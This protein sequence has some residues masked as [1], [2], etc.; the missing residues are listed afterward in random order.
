[1]ESVRLCALGSLCLTTDR[2]SY[3]ITAAAPALLLGYLICHAANG[4]PI[5]RSRLAGTLWPDES[6]TRARRNLTDTLYRLRRAIEVQIADRILHVDDETI[7]LG[8]VTIDVTE[9]RRLAASAQAA[10]WQAALD[11][12]AGDLLSDLDAD[13]LLAPREHLH[14]TYLATLERVCDARFTSGA[15]PEAL[16]IALRWVEA[17]PLSENAHAT[18]MRLY[19]RLGRHADALRQYDRLVQLLDR[20]LKI[21]PLPETRSLAASLRSEI[22]LTHRVPV[23]AASL[24]FVGRVAERAMLLEAVEAMIAGR[25]GMIAVEGEAGIGKSRLLDE[26]AASAKW[27]GVTV[28]TGR[29]TEAPSASPL[30]PLTEVL[31]SAFDGARRAQLEMLLPDETLAALAPLI[32]RWRD[33]AP[34]PDLPPLPARQ[35]FHRAWCEV[36]QTLA[37]IAPHVMVIDDAHWATQSVWEAL[38]EVAPLLA[39][40]RVLIVVAYRRA[41]LES[42]SGWKTVQHWERDG[43]LK[44]LTLSPLDQAEVA[45]LLP[46]DQNDTAAE[47]L[48]LTGGNPFYVMQALLSEQAGTAAHNVDQ[49]VLARALALS[50]VEREA[51]SAAAVLGMTVSF[52]LWSTLSDLDPARLIA[53]ADR[54]TSQAFLQ[55]IAAGYAF[56]HDLIQAIIY[57]QIDPERQQDLHRRAARAVREF[58]PDNAHALAFHLDR[59]GLA[60][61]AAAA[62]RRVGEQDRVRFAF[63]EARAAFERALD[64]L[65]DE[66]APIRIETLLALAQVCDVLGARECQHA[67]IESARRAARQLGDSPL[68]IRVLLLAGRLAAQTGQLPAA[69]DTYTEVL[70]LAQQTGDTTQ[71]IEAAFLLGDLANR[72]GDHEAASRRYQQVLAQAESLGDRGRMARALRGLGMI[73]RRNGQPAEAIRW[74]ERAL[75][76]QQALG[77][78]I[79][80]SITRVNLLS[81]CY[82]LGAWDR[83]LGLAEETQAL[84]EALHRKESIALVRHLQGLACFA[85]GDFEAA[86]RCLADAIRL[87]NEIGDRVTAGLA[88][89]AI[90]LVAEAED[91]VAGAQREYEAALAAAV[92]LN[93]TTEAAY[94]QHDLGA[95]LLRLNHHTAAIPLL[96]AARAKWRELGNDLLR[97]KSEAYLGLALLANG[98]R[99]TA[100]EL[101][102][103]NWQALQRGGLSGEQPQSWLW[104]LQRLLAQLNQSEQ[105]TAVLRAAYAELQ[106]QGEAIADDRLRQQFFNRVPLNRSIVAA[107]DQLNRR[108]RR[109]TIALVRADVPLGRKLTDR[110]YVTIEWTI[111]APE[112]DALTDPVDRRRHI[113]SRL[114]AEARSAGAAPTDHD[115]SRALDVSR[116]TIMRDIEALLHSGVKLPTRRRKP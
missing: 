102:E 1:M 21:E 15:L 51:L 17:D 34:L 115:L 75:T 11:L 71:Q 79:G 103:E 68:M 27:R 32:D 24:P 61:E 37:A 76:L 107:Y 28:V 22:E 13:W 23:R 97:L 48:A 56:A 90:G 9:F 45:Q 33:R 63:A 64:L 72:K 6:E 91:D 109:F 78:R 16:A 111:A 26:V 69:E 42:T 57:E 58:D 106:R 50:P 83:L 88:R 59:A 108:Q 40:L 65:P 86:R 74:F 84:A 43:R 25:G 99:S 110:D 7:A 49:L 87:Y 18:V 104:A 5:T 94:A 54:L 100:R 112:D 46:S 39:Q 60:E 14:E 101:A 66:P 20:E 92:D 30:A 55:P 19:A 44:A 113:L 85:L 116:R 31:D 89:N 95:L 114:I 4:Q 70:R 62:Y 53:T 35:R 105:A 77:D 36:L 96:D 52:R 73:A 98:D 80:E 81:S 47:V 3:P 67:A 12:Y 93:A 41:S 82:D 2:A 29:A 8:E 38:D 10:D